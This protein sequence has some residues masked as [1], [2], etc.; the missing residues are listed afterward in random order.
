MG[1]FRQY[2]MEIMTFLY[3][4]GLKYNKFN[5]SVSDF[6]WK[7]DD[8]NDP[9]LLAIQ[10]FN[11]YYKMAPP[12]FPQV[13]EF[14]DA[15]RKDVKIGIE[16]WFV[17]PTKLALDINFE[18]M[19][20]ELMY[21]PIDFHS[22]FPLPQI[23]P[24]QLELMQKL[25]ASNVRKKVL[26]ADTG[27]GKTLVL[28]AYGK[29]KKTIIVEPQ[30]GMQSQL[31]TKYN[32]P[33]IFGQ[34][35]YKCVA[36]DVPADESECRVLGSES[37]CKSYGDDC[38]WSKARSTIKE[39]ISKGNPVAVN[40]GNM[41]QWIS[42]ADVVIVDEFHTVFSQLSY[43]YKI[44]DDISEQDGMVWLQSEVVRLQDEIDDV[45][46]ELNEMARD[47]VP[48]DADKWG[49]YKG[50]QYELEWKNRFLDNYNHVVIHK[51]YGT[52]MKMDKVGTI[53]WLTDKYPNKEFV[54]VSATPLPI[55]DA[56]IISS[57]KSVAKKTNAPIIYFPTGNLSSRALQDSPENLT[58]AAE[59]IMLFYR[60]YSDH[61]HT[62]KMIIH[63]GNTTKHGVGISNY[64]TDK[65]LNVMKHEKGSLDEAIISFKDEDY[66]ALVVASADAGYDFYGD[67][68]GLQFILKVPYPTL[69]DEWR[70]LEKRYGASYKT[71]MYAHET[72]TQIV[73]ASGRICRGADDTG[74][75]IILDSK[76]TD[77]FNNY[78]AKFP[79][80]F[81]NR[82]YDNSGSLKN[83]YPSWQL[84]HYQKVE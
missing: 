62:R 34:A 43:S 73:Q 15:L 5:D 51:S 38:P 31:Q 1:T 6:F 78:R 18:K 42:F 58:H 66:D 53:E 69:G 60:Y 14:F 54:F 20:D 29:G 9:V 64:L 46:R 57:G 72:I 55:K 22:V 3:E 24:A 48:I 26:V 16:P 52:F 33:M 44:P 28:L 2:P 23:R 56:E 61:G 27:V 65:G 13:Y 75:T 8:H 77:L 63:S 36:Y 80:A 17:P 37:P 45:Y 79:D 84:E 68:F 50:L 40:P 70:A 74:V 7:L 19:H 21:T 10:F 59:M 82:L 71:N 32:V 76:F 25:F 11:K 35:H 67:V 41:F 49:V 12:D 83:V 4:N 81:I 47:G 30:R 39:N